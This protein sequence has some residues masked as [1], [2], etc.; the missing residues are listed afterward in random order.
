MAIH[1]IVDEII[2]VWIQVMDVRQHRWYKVHVQEGQNTSDYIKSHR[3]DLTLRRG[4]FY[5]CVSDES[6]RGSAGFSSCVCLDFNRRTKLRPACDPHIWSD[7]SDSLIRCTVKVLAEGRLDTLTWSFI[8]DPNRTLTSHL[9][10]TWIPRC[11][12]LTNH[13]LSGREMLSLNNVVLRMIIF[14]SLGKALSGK[15]AYCR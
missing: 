13:P 6:P 1:P 12:P 9:A 5:R 10:V 11:L 7:A 3:F 14:E 4:C 2:S 8:S 15:Q